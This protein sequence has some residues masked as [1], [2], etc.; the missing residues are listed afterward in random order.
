M[1]NIEHCEACEQPVASD[2]GIIEPEQGGTICHRCAFEMTASEL[3]LA[4]QQLRGAVEKLEDENKQLRILLY[5]VVTNS[6]VQVM[7]SPQ[8]RKQATVMISNSNAVR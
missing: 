6:N 4:R 2:G 7:L 1:G 5:E 3:A 8:W